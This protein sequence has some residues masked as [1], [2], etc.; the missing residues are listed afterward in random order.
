MNDSEGKNGTLL[1]LFYGIC[2]CVCEKFKTYQFEDDEQDEARG[3]WKKNQK[4][5]SFLNYFDFF[6]LTI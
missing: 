2:V 4:K 6:C 1:L 5:I 3:W